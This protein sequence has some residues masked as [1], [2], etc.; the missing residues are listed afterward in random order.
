VSR[1]EQGL[2]VRGSQKWL[3]ILI[4][5]HPELLDRVL[6]DRI[7]LAKDERVHWLS[8]LRDDHYAEY[9]DREFLERLGVSLD[10]VS[11]RAFWPDLGPRWDALA[12]T[13]R[14][15]L[16]L[17]EAK[18]HIPELVTNPTKATGKALLR[19]RESL[20]K[21]KR[22]LGS[23]S[24]VDWAMGFYQYTNRLAHLYLLRVLNGLPAY[25]VFLY[26]TNDR[27]M[28][29]PATQAEWEGA[30]ALLESLLDI[31]AHKLSAYVLDV[32]VDVRQLDPALA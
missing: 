29:G 24:D 10:L 14:G 12:K 15:D 26:F 31:R 11:L 30:I 32:F 18:S 4:N 5:E 1:T 7:G 3:Q 22:A 19:I 20:D 6:A 9:R 27:E 2:A 16:L 21:A 28:N 23:H 25:L 13:D 17:L 8:P